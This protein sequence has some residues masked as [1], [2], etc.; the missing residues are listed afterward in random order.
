MFSDFD[1]IFGNQ[2]SISKVN[3]G[4]HKCLSKPT[5]NPVNFCNVFR[6]RKVTEISHHPGAFENP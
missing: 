4:I 3:R 2:L 6:W 5:G 1:S